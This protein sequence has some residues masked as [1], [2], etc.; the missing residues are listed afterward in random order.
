[1]LYRCTPDAWSHVGKPI[2]LLLG[3]LTVI[4]FT[5]S[6]LLVPLTCLVLPLVYL[7]V[8]PPWAVAI[9]G[10]WLGTVL[11]SFLFPQ[12]EW[13]WARKVGQL[14]YDLF[15]FHHNLTPENR[16]ERIRLGRENQ[17]IIAMHPHGV[18][19]LHAYLWAAY[20]DQYL[21]NAESGL[22]GFGAGADILEYLPVL[23][24]IMGWLTAGSA[25]Y[26]VLKQGLLRGKS[27]PANRVG[28][29]PRNLFIL[30]GGVAE[31]FTSAPGDHTIVFAQ[32]RGLARLSCETGAQLVP[33]YVFGA[34]DFFGNALKSDSFLARLSRR[35]KAGIAIFWGLGGL[36]FVPFAPKVTLVIGDP[37]PVPEW[38]PADGCDT[39]PAEVVGRLHAE[40]LK[41]I[42]KLF[43]DYKAEAGYPD[44]TLNVQ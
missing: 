2:R 23:R 4:G 16:E 26:G 40:Y 37:I 12:V 11:A 13:P 27:P 38:E 3:W 28:R 5:T 31:I 32:R 20:C 29:R 36:P 7:F 43:D 35:L 18:I 9:I 8:A 42:V 21:S 22:Y 15:D 34:T 6:F 24:N 14:W 41:A 1:M 30:P 17:Y 10:S 39:P 19:P 44:A 25:T 33:A